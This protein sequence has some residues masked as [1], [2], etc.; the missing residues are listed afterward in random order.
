[1]DIN[2]VGLLIAYQ[3]ER[4]KASA[5]MVCEG[6]CSRSF[7]AR[8]EKGV[9][10]C[11]KIMAEAL[12][13]RVGV[14]SDELL[15]FLREKEY[16]CLE[17]KE[18]LL[19]AIAETD[20]K[21]A[22]KL[23]AEY[24]K[25]TKGKCTLHEQFLL[26]AE[27]VLQWNLYRNGRKTR[28]KILEPT[29]AKLN[30]AWKITREPYDLLGEC[31]QYMD[32]Q[33]LTIRTLYYRLLEEKGED[34]EALEGYR[35]TL[36]YAKLRLEPKGC[37]KFFPFL[38]YRMLKIMERLGG[39]EKEQESLYAECWDLMRKYGSMTCLK[40]LAAYRKEYLQKRIQVEKFGEDAE[41]RKILQQEAAQMQEII[42]VMEWMERTYEIQKNDW[43]TNRLFGREEVFLLSETIRG[44]RIAFGMSQERL[45]EGVC[46]AVT[47]SRIET[48]YSNCNATNLW[49]LMEKLN[50]PGGTAMVSSYTGTV[51]TYE[52]TTEIA[53]LSSFAKYEEIAPIFE[54][55][56]EQ[57]GDDHYTRQYMLYKETALR[58]NLGQIDHAEAWKLQKEALH[59]TVPK[60]SP[61]ELTTW[62]F[63]RTEAMI[64]QS[65]SY[66]AKKCGKT[67]ETVEW[68]E[69]LLSACQRQ[70]LHR[71]HY[72]RSY[73]LTLRN[74]SDLLDQTQEYERAICYAKEA[75][76]LSLETED[77]SGLG[78]CFYSVGWN[79]EQLWENG[80]YTKEDS[81]PY[82]RAAVLLF[83]LYE[84]SSNIA[85]MQ[86][87]WIDYYAD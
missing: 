21:A 26:L 7:M 38:S 75:T 31:P 53:R 39:M 45:A 62:A 76:I 34:R 37:A 85:F 51:N 46:D 4:V 3:R 83:Q 61:T 84:T 60:K 73:A 68:L 22:D 77:A 35:R 56:K 72:Y 17:T 1:M 11:E 52:L 49:K 69:L 12:L 33:E 32:T 44:R 19:T 23:F 30:E 57:A 2:Q 40:E 48:G 55:L 70:P 54:K 63:T 10:G 47:L 64:I 18:N 42:S 28:E 65:M 16:H 71:L 59:L 14:A 66:C 86:K 15:Y 29:L 78:T 8:L 27:S 24:R 50:L 25:I 20:T 87:H 43:F 81:R 9:R 82:V 5:E 79:M 36:K 13:Q 74:L 80:V 58:K 41:K 6:I 67:A